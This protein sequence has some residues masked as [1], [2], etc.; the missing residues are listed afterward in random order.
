MAWEG[1]ESRTLHNIVGQNIVALCDVDWDYAGDVFKTYP[2]AKQWKDFRKMLEQQ[3]DIDAVV[4][5]TPDHSHAIQAMVAMQLGKHVYVQK[6]LTHTVWEA[7]Q[8]TEA[9]RKYKVATQM[10]NEG[11]SQ[12]SVRK[13]TE[14][15]RSGVIGEVKE[16]YVTTNRPIW[17]QGLERP[18]GT[19]EGPRLPGLGSFSGHRTLPPLQRS[20]S[21]MELE[22]MVGLWYR[23][24]GR[25]GLPCDGC[26]ILRHETKVPCQGPG[27]FNRCKY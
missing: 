5:A 4:I 24:T 10:G 13:I 6:P 22:S 27:E 7:R 16:V 18:Q 25:H 12:E 26:S 15:I 3:K 14:L 17:P 8:L 2:S 23:C 1:K 9:A 11:H 19:T 21:P 20:L